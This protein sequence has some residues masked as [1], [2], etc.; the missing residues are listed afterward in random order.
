[1]SW[2]NPIIFSGTMTQK[3]GIYD[4]VKA[5]I[6]LLNKGTEVNLI[7]NGKDT[8]NKSTGNS[9]K[10]ELLNLI[11]DVFKQNFIFNG[12]ITR[13]ELLCQYK[14]ST[15]AIFPSFAEAF[16]IAPMEAMSVGIPTIFS[17]ECSGSELISDKVDGLLIDP[18]SEESIA[19]A[20]MYILND[21][22]EA[23]KIGHR[24]Q[25]KILMNFSKKVMSTKTLQF[26]ENI[27]A[28]YNI[29]LTRLHF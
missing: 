26:Y 17:K 22:E 15:A 27:R 21:P 28:I 7:I 6:F 1:M 8:T 5:V 2:K 10:E 25:E 11:P 9:V 12:H 20:I 23:K 16:A 19:Q 24:G 18:S 3:K 29:S 13:N 4:L 14:Y